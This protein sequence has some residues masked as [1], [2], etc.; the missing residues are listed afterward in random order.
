MNR[1]VKL[2]TVP[3]SGSESIIKLNYPHKTL[4]VLRGEQKT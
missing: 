2:N 1:K 3:V 4:R